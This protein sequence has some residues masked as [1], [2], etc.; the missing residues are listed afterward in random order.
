MTLSYS[1]VS[2]VVRS[3]TC[4]FPLY[5]PC[6]LLSVV[7]SSLHISLRV[8]AYLRL[9]SVRQP[10][11]STPPPPSTQAYLASLTHIFISISHY[12]QLPSTFVVPMSSR[13]QMLELGEQSIRPFL[14]C[15]FPLHR[16]FPPQS[17]TLLPNPTTTPPSCCQ[18]DWNIILS[19][20]SD[21]VFLISAS[22]CAYTLVLPLRTFTARAS[23]LVS[24]SVPF[25][26]FSLSSTPGI[27][28]FTV[29]VYC[30]TPP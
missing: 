29:C 26:S 30:Y 17:P 5:L 10:V 9:Q 7:L 20:D 8:C 15:S 2:H 27:S 25:R 12:K 1:Y 24:S 19:V 16:T 21:A 23:L 13:H 18:N 14:I 6:P 4:I 3:M 22:P 28:P 11:L